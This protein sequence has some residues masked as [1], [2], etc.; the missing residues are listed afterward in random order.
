AVLCAAGVARRVVLV[1]QVEVVRE[2]VR[3]HANAAVLRLDRVVADPDAGAADL[4]A[5]ELVVARAGGSDQVVERI[6]A[7][8]PDRV[9]ALR[10]A[11]GLLADAGVD[12]LEVVDIA[13]RLVEVAV[14]VVVVPIPDVE[15]LQV[16][17]DL[18]RRLA[19][20]DLP[21]VPGRERITDERPDGRADVAPA[22][23]RAV[24]GL[25]ERDLDP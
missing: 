4:D 1:R 14:T 16:L 2:L 11:A 13:V 17:V 10:A 25:V 22:Q 19:R 21:V 18:R 7:M 9:G 12:R 3:E 23:V 6:P 20:S 5:A 24:A 15:L 8:R